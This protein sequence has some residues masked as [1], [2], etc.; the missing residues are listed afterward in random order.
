MNQKPSYVV[1]PSVNHSE[2][3]ESFSAPHSSQDIP[4]MC[5]IEKRK[6]KLSS[7]QPHPFSEQGPQE[8]RTLTGEMCNVGKVHVAVQCPP[9]SAVKR[10]KT[11]VTRKE[12]NL[13]RI[14]V[15]MVSDSDGDRPIHVAVAQ[16]NLRLVHKLCSL[17]LKA[18]ISLDLT[19]YLRQTP[20]H[21]A[22]MLGNVEIVQLL[23]KYG[24]SVTLRDR[25]GNS[26]IHLAV[27]SGAN[28]DVLGLILS[29]P[30]AKDILNALDH[31]GY[32][33][34]HYAILKNNKTAVWCL[35]KV[36]A[37]MNV[38]DPPP[39]YRTNKVITVAIV[40]KPN[41]VAS[42]PGHLRPRKNNYE[43]VAEE[44]MSSIHH[45]VTV[46]SAN[47][48]C[49]VCLRSEVFN[50]G[51]FSTGSIHDLGAVKKAIKYEIHAMRC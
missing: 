34:L 19:N 21:L 39:H 16:E 31:E 8:E 14:Q 51:A 12:V 15:A 27:K 22:V 13:L 18:S 37:Q 17:M 47:K 7:S 45:H 50:L 42:L 33:A 2:S 24:S 11:N 29:H 30:N 38:I 46:K 26:A 44:L 49:L 25:N 3:Q 28:K 32:S 20:F 6:R 41:S 5:N 9:H 23:I 43:S 35:Q 40:F 4:P 10:T 1:C 36:G 48:A